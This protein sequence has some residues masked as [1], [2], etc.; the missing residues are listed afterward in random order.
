MPIM[1]FVSH[2]SVKFLF[3]IR[4][5]VVELWAW[6]KWLVGWAAALAV[7]IAV[8]CAARKL[9]TL[10]VLLCWHHLLQILSQ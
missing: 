9:D 1:I 6:S 5:E 10:T 8:V 4:S 3:D 7:A 2:T